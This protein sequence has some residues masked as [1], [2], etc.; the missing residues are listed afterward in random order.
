MKVYLET[1]KGEKVERVWDVH[2]VLWGL[3][4]PP[5]DASYPLLACV[6]PYGRTVFNRLQMQPFLEEW[7]R[8]AAGARDELETKTLSLI[9]NLAERCRETQ[10]YYLVFVGE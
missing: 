3:L 5:P 8:L 9:T 10:N 2:G 4:M 1:D 6:D 7:G